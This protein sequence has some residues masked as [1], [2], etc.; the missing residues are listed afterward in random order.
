[1]RKILAA[2][3]AFGIVAAATA[4]SVAFD[5]KTFWEMHPPK[6]GS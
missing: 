5:S 4:P 6:S 3:L 1:M 2:V